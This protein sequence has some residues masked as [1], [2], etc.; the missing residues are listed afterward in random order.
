MLA[1]AGT[2]AI[3]VLLLI[4]AD[5]VVVVSP[6]R[7]DPPAPRIEMIDIT[8]PVMQPPPPPI[9][10]ADPE[11]PPEPAPPPPAVK[12]PPPPKAAPRARAIRPAAAT[13]PAETAPAA[14]PPPTTSSA[15][16]PDPGGAPTVAMP[17]LPP[18]ATGV[19]VAIGKRNTG[20]IGRGGTGGGTGSGTGQGAG[21]EVAAP[22]SIATIKT[23]AMPKGDYSFIN[24]GKDYPAEANRLRIEGVIRV[25]LVV[26]ETGAVKSAVVLNKLGHGLDELALARARTIAFEPARDTNNK[27]VASVVVWTFTMTLPK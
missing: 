23:R 12:A 24:A 13:P 21:A 3:H 15:A 10:S 2:V 7:P 14:E 9:K 6:R 4:G 19:G 17:D 22:A 27:P 8:P 16:D 5:A 11:P 26:D 18:S 20:K 1:F 25:R